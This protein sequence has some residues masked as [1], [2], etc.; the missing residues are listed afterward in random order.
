MQ[1]IGSSA[2]HRLMRVGEKVNL[3]A[4]WLLV[5]QVYFSPILNDS[6]SAEDTSSESE[7]DKT[8]QLRV[9]NIEMSTT[10]DTLLMSGES[11]ISL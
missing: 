5:V 8:F 6:K 9:R 7:K 11:L 3:K 2:H 1:S 10:I 4:T